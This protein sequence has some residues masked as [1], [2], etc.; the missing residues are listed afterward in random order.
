VTL[1][2]RALALLALLIERQGQLVSKDE[3]MKTVWP[4][5]AIEE[6]NV[7]G[8]ISASRR[9][10]DRIANRTATSRRSQDAATGLC[11]R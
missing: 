3:I 6:G 11:L 7:T 4:G 2:S 8:L 5:I 1:G 9:V 10:L